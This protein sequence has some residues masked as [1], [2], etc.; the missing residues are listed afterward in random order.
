MKQFDELNQ[1]LSLPINNCDYKPFDTALNDKII[2]YGAGSL[3]KMAVSLLLKI[4]IKPKYI[5]DKNLSGDIEGINIVKVDNI[6]STDLANCTF[7]ICI[8]SIE[9]M[10][11]FNYLKQLGCK[12]V[13]QFYDYAEIYLKDYLG[14]GWAKLNLNREDLCGIK[15]SYEYFRYDANSFAH[16]MQFL[17]WR[18]RRVEKIYL[19]FPVLSNKKY[20]KAPCMPKLSEKESYLDGGAHFGGV[21]KDFV[22][23]VDMKYKTIWAFEPDNNNLLVMKANLFNIDRIVYLPVV[24]SNKN[25][26]VKFVDGLGFASKVYKFGN[27][28]VSSRTIDSL[29]INP[30]IIKL[31]IEGYELKALQGAIKTIKRVRP[32]LIVL[33]DHNDDGLYR[34]SNFLIDLKGYKTY[35]YLHDYCGNNGIFYSIPK[36]RLIDAK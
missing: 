7:I 14:N 5:I 29:N 8:S 9:F 21:I 36:E 18:L 32:I 35:F 11:V 6:S 31:H 3:G 10:P 2:L 22:S 26:S 25:M 13:I 33:A 30:S 1:L 34:I 12:S 16:Y 20:F 15:K 17:W 28:V 27:K 24:L 4:N 23:T 19:E